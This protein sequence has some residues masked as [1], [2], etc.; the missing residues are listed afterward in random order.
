[1]T[2]LKDGAG[3]ALTCA[4]ESLSVADTFLTIAREMIDARN[5]A[6][7][8]VGLLAT[9]LLDGAV[10]TADERAALEGLIATVET[11]KTA[12]AVLAKKLEDAARRLPRTRQ[13]VDQFERSIRQMRVS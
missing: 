4:R 10:V 3:R 5:R 6:L 7:L 8:Q 1:M 13:H 11:E 9:R 2:D 12:A